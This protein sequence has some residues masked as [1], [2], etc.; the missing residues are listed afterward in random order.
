MKRKESRRRQPRSDAP[1]KVRQIFNDLVASVPP[2]HFR[3][4]DADLL[5]QHAQSI[6]LARKAYGELEKHVSWLLT[7]F[8]IGGTL[9][10]LH[11]TILGF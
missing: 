1:A 8:V 2:E 9:G 5:E 10:A 3:P 11:W 6:A 7:A 4:G